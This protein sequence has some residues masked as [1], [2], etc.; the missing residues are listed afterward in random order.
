VSVSIR[1]LHPLELS[2]TGSCQKSTFSTGMMLYESPDSRAGCFMVQI[3]W[4]SGRTFKI[5][6]H[7]IAHSTCDTNISHW[8]HRSDQSDLVFRNSSDNRSCLKLS[9]Y[10]DGTVSSHFTAHNILP[11][12]V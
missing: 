2:F 4:T 5:Q 10:H 11:V 6:G 12:T 7:R 8:F 3:A 9:H 1:M